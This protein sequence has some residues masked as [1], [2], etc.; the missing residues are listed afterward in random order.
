[1]YLMY[2]FS[3]Y[4]SSELAATNLRPLWQHDIL[5]QATKHPFLM[6]GL[7]AMSALHLADKEPEFATE[8]LPL[9]IHHQN[10]AISSFRPALLAIS[11]EN[12][13]AV[14]AQ[15]SVISMSSMFLACVRSR[16]DQN[17]E[18][19]VDEFIEPYLLTI[20]IAEVVAAATNWIIKGPLA[21]MLD[22][23][24]VPNVDHSIIPYEV[25]SHFD[26][27]RDKFRHNFKDEEELS[28]LLKALGSLEYICKELVTGFKG[29]EDNP[30]MVW[31]WTS[32]VP[33]SYTSILR[34]HHP[35]ALVLYA[36]FAILSKKYDSNWFHRGWSDLAVT[37]ISNALSPEWRALIKR[38]EIPQP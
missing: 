7:L 3:V 25:Q 9:S 28:A 8:Y 15:A 11:E 37:T 19:S 5:K 22:G 26:N 35:G 21:V 33:H 36:H 31:K 6:H 4:T 20:G 29:C 34:T 18:P 14:F 27:I 1:M 2:H 30:G 12:C 17:Y 10:L 38:I 13:H 16:V 24:V 32:T 23:H